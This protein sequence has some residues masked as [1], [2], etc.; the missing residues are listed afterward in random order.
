MEKKSDILSRVAHKTGMTVPDGY[1]ADFAARME[2]ALPERSE[3]QAVDERPRTL[4]QRVRPYCYMAAMFAGIWCMLRMFT[5]MGGAGADLSID[6][7]PGVS[8]ALANERF[9][10]DY[11]VPTVDEYDFFEDLYDQD[12]MTPEEFFD[13]DSEDTTHDSDHELVLPTVAE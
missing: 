9:V 2:Q 8:T 10:K 13:F 7:Y 12:D 11:I 5:M 6:N 1:F 3:M 4:W